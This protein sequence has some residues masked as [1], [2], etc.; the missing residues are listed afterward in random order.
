MRRKVF[1]LDR[2]LLLACY[3]R[4]SPGAGFLRWPGS[5]LLC[6]VSPTCALLEGGWEHQPH[7]G[8]HM[9]RAPSL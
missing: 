8:S 1:K 9:P 2:V 6:T 4:A 3:S 5:F 7:S